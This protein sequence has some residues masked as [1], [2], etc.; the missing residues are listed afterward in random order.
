MNIDLIFVLVG[1][2]VTL[3]TSLVK[4]DHWSTKAKQVVNL[5]LSL[6]GGVVA[7]Y[8]TDKNIDPTA[9]L[10]SWAATLGVSQA[11]FAFLLKDTGLDKILASIGAP[12]K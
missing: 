9:L 6:A 7:T 5:V 1:V 3:F 11:I 4:Q 10:T 12:K 2:A 8:L